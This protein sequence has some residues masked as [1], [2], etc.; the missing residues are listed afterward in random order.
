MEGIILELA[1]VG[2]TISPTEEPLAIPLVF[3]VLALVVSPIKVRLCARAMSLAR[4][5]LAIKFASIS[6]LICHVPMLKAT[7]KLPFV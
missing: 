4:A 5:E 7:L 3:L 2:A 1:S 6:L